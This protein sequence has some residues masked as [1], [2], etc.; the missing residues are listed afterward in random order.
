MENNGG[1][2]TERCI[3]SSAAVLLIMD[4]KSGKSSRNRL[5]LNNMTFKISNFRSKSVGC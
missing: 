2:S 3:M 5:H 4:K 1:G